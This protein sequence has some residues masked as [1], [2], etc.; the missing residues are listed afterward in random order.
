MY[1]NQDMNLLNKINQIYFDFINNKIDIHIALKESISLILENTDI[2]VIKIPKLN[3]KVFTEYYFKSNDNID[4]NYNSEIINS[5]ENIILVNVKNQNNTNLTPTNLDKT[6][7]LNFPNKQL[8]VDSLLVYNFNFE[9]IDYKIILVC[10]NQKDEINYN[11]ISYCLFSIANIY[12]CYLKSEKNETNL[13]ELKESKSIF[14]ELVHNMDEMFY[15]RDVQS[16]KILYISDGFERICKKIGLDKISFS[17]F[18][19]YLHPDDTDEIEIK[20]QIII[21]EKK[22]VESAYRLLLPNG[23]MEW[24]LF[25][26]YPI[27]NSEGEVVKITGLGKLI[28]N[29]KN[30]EDKLKESQARIESIVEHTKM[31]FMLVDKNKNILLMD[32]LTKQSS[33]IVH[34]RQLKEN[35]SILHIIPPSILPSFESNFAKALAGEEI[36][37]ERSIMFKDGIERFLD[38]HYYPVIE[39]NKEIHSVVISIIDQTQNKASELKLKI[40][41]RNLATLVDNSQDAIFSIDE[42]FKINV[43]NIEAQK[44][45]FLNNEHLLTSGSDFIE[46]VGI[47]NFN[48]YWSDHFKNVFTGNN[49]GFEYY[50]L[51]SNSTFDILISPIFDENLYVFGATVISRNISQKKEIEKKL[52]STSEFLQQVTDLAIEGILTF[53][54][55]RD[56]NHQIIDFVCTYANNSA[57][58]ILNPV[59]E[60]IV[61]NNLKSMIKMVNLNHLFETY[62][63]VVENGKTIEFENYFKGNKN[64]YWFQNGVAKMNDGII[65][66]FMN[67]TNIKKAD[68]KLRIYLDE[69]KEL[70]SSKDKFFSI[71][72]HDLR[73]PIS[74]FKSLTSSILSTLEQRDKAEIRETLELLDRSTYSLSKLLED[75]IQWSKL[76]RK[77][78]HF[79]PEAY[80]LKDIIDSIYNLYENN[81]TKKKILLNNSVNNNTYVYVDYN[82]ISTIL[83]NLISNAIKYT[84]VGGRIDICVILDAE[85]YNS[86]EVSIDENY[87][88]KVEDNGI[89]MSEESIKLLFNIDS[90]FSNLGTAEERGTGMGLL[91]CY[92]LL[93]YNK[94]K[95]WIEAELNKGT[96]VFFTFPKIDITLYLQNEL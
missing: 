72:A 74:A 22:A 55:I 16:K 83:R 46:L 9:D 1:K 18:L 54:S 48:L 45:F 14:N 13:Q 31:N 35:D 71:V 86:H 38:I 29:R 42:N 11:F 12:I 77:V 44:L 85:L 70:N 62:K 33:N 89:G 92:D 25:K 8:I 20:Y 79:E 34:N 5:L 78:L 58:Q 91:L 32:K 17:D 82:L 30:L 90:H 66:S 60:K 80:P 81:A 3:F 10:N 27:L 57:I 68:Q 19:S 93:T 67:I 96:K 69:M 75:L 15:I 39:F 6:Y 40:S 2:V 24:I 76:Q 88:I 61:G 37:L 87:I 84:K 26:S 56:D 95:I 7:S 49:V 73:G 41:E 94:C 36:K 63:A 52:K 59:S 28:T 47:E 50:D 43:F 21:N 64:E 4:L 53:E 23:S 65:T 51:Y